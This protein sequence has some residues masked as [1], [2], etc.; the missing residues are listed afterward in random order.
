[1]GLKPAAI[2]QKLNAG[3]TLQLLP[4]RDDLPSPLTP[5]EWSAVLDRDSRQ[6][7]FLGIISDVRMLRLYQGLTA[8]DAETARYIAAR[9]SLA[10][11]LVDGDRRVFAVFA[12]SLTV[13]GRSVAVPG[14]ASCERVWERIVG[15]APAD[16]ERFIRR[17]FNNDDGR[18]AY[19]YSAVESLPPADV[20]RA[21]FDQ[22]GKPSEKAAE[23]LYEIFRQSPPAW[24]IRQRPIP[25]AF[26]PAAALIDLEWGGDGRLL[27]PPWQRLWR[28][29]LDRSDIPERPERTVRDL[30]DDGLIT[31]SWIMG[32]VFAE[33]ELTRARFDLVRFAQRMYATPTKQQ[34]ADVL[35]GLIAFRR[36]PS[37]MLGFERMGLRDP[38]LL[39]ALARATERLGDGQSEESALAIQQWQGIVALLEALRRTGALD[40]QTVSSWLKS[41][42]AVQPSG[43]GAFEGRLAR[44]L[45]T[46]LVPRLSR[47]AAAGESFEAKLLP[48]LAGPVAAA[49]QTVEWEG[50]AY[51][52][53]IQGAQ[54]A[55][56]L[57]IARIQLRPSL[58]DV[59]ALARGAEALASA[60]KVEQVRRTA[61]ELRARLTA[62]KAPLPA[63]TGPAPKKPRSGADHLTKVLKDLDRI[64]RDKDVRRAERIAPVLK[65]LSDVTL[66]DVIPAL[67]YAGRLGAAL[68]APDQYADLWRRHD[69]GFGLKTR[70]V[71]AVPWRPAELEADDGRGGFLTGSLIGFDVALGRSLLRRLAGENIAKPGVVPEADVLAMLQ[72]VALSASRNSTPDG[73]DPLPALVA[74]VQRGRERWQQMR[75]SQETNLS[76]VVGARRAALTRWS[77]VHERGA[78]ADQITLVEL[79]HLGRGELTDDALSILGI[80]STVKDG[81]WCTR[82]PKLER[83]R[84]SAADRTL[85][86]AAADLSIR[87]A[88]LLVEVGMPVAVFPSVLAAAITDVLDRFAPFVEDDWAALARLVRGVERD[89]EE[90][91]LFALVSTREL[92]TTRAATAGRE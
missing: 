27:G 9:P 55:R 57:R 4:A 25:V 85:A 30:D 75:R 49:G 43:S 44:W 52:V 29:V 3:E 7:A 80:A 32:M 74:A 18:L 42:A 88:E 66:A 13:R 91:F 11:D 1:M 33:P 92:A 82:F 83:F 56:A 65:W 5:A 14:G 70:G 79:L 16:A 17:I 38:G 15:T 36:Y 10:H 76:E 69:F 23:R 22:T 73:A 60:K 24:D 81:C 67:L 41:A 2:A 53:D 89:R 37:L 12:S 35:V 20:R 51:R 86:R 45:D 34:A 68:G 31:T 21:F 63:G 87:L 54:S 61:V 8:V 72:T 71:V 28:E 62:F 48:L 6:H 39:A 84:S 47:E 26:D 19:F 50:L 58:D 64:K 77:E 78:V 40:V 90:Q 59:L 46:T